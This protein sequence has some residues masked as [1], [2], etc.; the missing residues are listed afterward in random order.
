[1]TGVGPH[2]ATDVAGDDSSVDENSQQELVVE[3]RD[4]Y[5]NPVS[6]ATVN[7]TL[8]SGLAT[9]R[10]TAQSQTGTTL[11][12]L[13][14]DSEGRVEITY[15]APADFDGSNQQVEVRVSTN[16]TPGGTFAPG[17]RTNLSYN[18]TAVNADGSG[19][20]GGGGSDGAY[21]THWDESAIDGETGM[22]CYANGTCRYNRSK[23]AT[24]T[25]TAE[26]VPVA[27][28]ATVEYAVNNTTVATFAS[29]QT[30][31]GSDGR[32][33][34]DLDTATTGN[35]TLYAWSG[36]SGDNLTVE[37]YD[38]TGGGP[39]NDPPRAEF[40]AT[41]SNL[42]CS[43]DASGS[44]DPEG[45]I[46]SYDWSF[47]DGTNG[48]GET[49]S[50]TYGSSGTYNVTL[51]VTDNKGQTDT[52]Q[53]TV[54]V[55]SAGTS[56][57]VA[58]RVDDLSH[59]DQDQVEYVAS[60]D[61]KNTNASFVRVS[62]V[63]DNVNRGESATGVR[64]STAARSGVRYSLGYGADEDW[65]VTVRV[66]YEDDSGQEYVATSKRITDTADAL[67]PSANEN[68]AEAGSPTVSSFSVTDRT[69][70]GQGPRY[71]IDYAVTTN[72]NFSRV[73]GAAISLGGGGADVANATA[74]SGQIDLAPGYGQGTQF[75][76]KLLVFDDDGAVVA[77][78]AETDTAN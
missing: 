51:T 33:T 7:A 36:G 17:A 61:V 73:E 60:Y 43:F 12:N 19:L 10:I 42:T 24:V 13:T 48:T 62:V 28:G 31:T 49:T 9:D 65:N 77:V 59:V 38:P 74:T 29:E 2:Y 40:T 64:N 4:R 6:G 21:Q 41:C 58:F 50:H 18:L 55:S 22:T 54:T 63:F 44:S 25:L 30:T 78:R 26:T 11:T 56:P 32:A 15:D 34:V 27:Q 1:V 69:N 14:T 47:G 71:R 57:S 5:N 35:V 52:V 75:R 16:E 68:L 37:V 8:V 23:G 3:V 39:G 53:K 20:G 72:G 70:R 46:Q 76:I 67:N 66:V 45:N